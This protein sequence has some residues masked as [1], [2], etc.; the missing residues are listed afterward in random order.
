LRVATFTV[1]FILNV[2]AECGFELFTAD[3]KDAYLIPDIAEV[4]EP[5]TYG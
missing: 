2:A 5:D 1:F 4:S 3:L